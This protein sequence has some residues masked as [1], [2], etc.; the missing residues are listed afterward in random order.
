MADT[1]GKVTRFAAELVEDAAAE[2][3]RQSRSAT[4]QLD[5]WVRLGRAVSRYTS[6]SRQR[7]EAALAGELP[8]ADLADEEGMVFNAEVAA[9]IEENLTATSYQSLLAA[10]GVT[11][12]ALDT[13]GQLVEH[14]PDGTTA[15]FRAGR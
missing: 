6:A 4:Q 14:R 7:V 11:T 10:A 12:V 5:H 15:P 8:L 9:R 2:G 1:Q 13:D 3:A